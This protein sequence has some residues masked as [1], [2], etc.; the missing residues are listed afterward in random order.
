MQWVYC[1]RHRYSD[2]VAECGLHCYL[3]M[4]NYMDSASD[5]LLEYTR[6]KDGRTLLTMKY[7]E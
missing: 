3:S 4:G 7:M 5:T 1:K 6:I 2:S